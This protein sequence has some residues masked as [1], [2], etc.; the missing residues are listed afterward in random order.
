MRTVSSVGVIL[1][2]EIAYVI[3]VCEGFRVKDVAAA[4]LS[5]SL[6][7]ALYFSFRFQMGKGFFSVDGLH[8]AAFQFVIAVVEHFPRLC[9]FVEISGQCILQKLMRRASAL[10]YEV[11]ELLF[12]VGSEMDFHGL[13]IGKSIGC[14][15]EPDGVQNSL[16]FSNASVYCISRQAP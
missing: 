4:H 10:G 15:K 5:S 1:C 6:A 7:V 16:N 14:G 8:P 3:K 9:Q 2:D 13:N 11:V 12:N